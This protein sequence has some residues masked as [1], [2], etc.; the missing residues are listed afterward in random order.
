LRSKASYESSR[1][2]D[3]STLMIGIKLTA[4]NK[5]IMTLS[6]NVTLAMKI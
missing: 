3:C 2:E 1:P 6:I 5:E 4:L